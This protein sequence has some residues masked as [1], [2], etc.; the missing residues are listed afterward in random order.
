MM[1]QVQCQC[2]R[3]LI[4]NDIIERDD[5]DIMLLWICRVCGV[6]FGM[7]GEVHALSFL[8]KGCIWTDEARHVLDRLPPYIEVLVR[9]EVV[10]Y[11]G[12]TGASVI[13][14]ATIKEA[15]NRGR[16]SWDPV[17]EARLTN[18]P[19]SVRTMARVE[20]ERTAMERGMSEVTV[21]LMEEL[22]ARY[23]GMAM[24]GDTR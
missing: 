8:L 2:G 16:V 6:Q 3:D 15:R 17:A 24:S 18:V 22:K 23:F 4:L 5:A 1:N 10:A 11:A 21:P 12:E 19:A 7:E 13:T 9:E 14:S 20:L